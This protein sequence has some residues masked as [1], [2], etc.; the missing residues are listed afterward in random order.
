LE[1]IVCLN[2]K[3]NKKHTKKYKKRKFTKKKLQKNLGIKSPKEEINNTK[4]SDEN[5]EL[6]DEENGFILNSFKG[7]SCTNYFY[8]DNKITN[9]FKN[10]NLF[11]YKKI[12]FKIENNEIINVNK[13]ENDLNTPIKDDIIKDN[14]VFDISNV[15]KHEENFANDEELFMFYGTKPCSNDVQEK[16]NII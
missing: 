8:Q 1:N 13:I 2:S 6:E 10:P 12:E 11:R 14:I 4:A 15:K 16:S 3:E 9:L 7:K 5:L